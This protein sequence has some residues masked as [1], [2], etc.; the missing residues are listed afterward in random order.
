MIRPTK[1]DF[2]NTY[3]NQAW[4]N[5]FGANGL[6]IVCKTATEIRAEGGQDVGRINWGGA[7]FNQAYE[8]ARPDS[9]IV[10]IYFVRLAIDLKVSRSDAITSFPSVVGGGGSNFDIAVEDLQE[11]IEK[12]VLRSH[13]DTMFAPDGV[14]WA[15]NETYS[16]R[17][18]FQ[19]G[20]RSIIPADLAFDFMD[21][22]I[23]TNQPVP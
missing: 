4:L 10:E 12:R 11:K 13:Y 7:E 23:P 5:E 14:A 3:Q 21:G 19:K 15:G 8:S 20:Y 2:N 6:D 9:R 16:E 17:D 1:I 22:Q 18:L